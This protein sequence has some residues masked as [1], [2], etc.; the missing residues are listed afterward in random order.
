MYEERYVVFLDLLGFREMIKRSLNDQ[1][2]YTRIQTALQIG[3]TTP[4]PWLPS[5]ESSFKAT[6]ASDSVILSA[7]RNEVG[8]RDILEALCNYGIRLLGYPMMARG[9]VAAGLFTHENW[10]FWGPAYL[11]AMDAE[12][13]RAVYPRI[14]LSQDVA[15]EAAS[16][17]Y[18]EYVRVDQNDSESYVDYCPNNALEFAD[19]WEDRMTRAMLARYL[20]AYRFAISQE[21][22]DTSGPKAADLAEHCAEHFDESDVELFIEIYGFA[23]SDEGMNKGKESS[24]EFAWDWFENHYGK[25]FEKFKRLYS[26]AYRTDGLAMGRDDSEQYAFDNL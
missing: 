4:P 6:A 17:G 5:E 12:G 1:E 14:I 15:K 9:A 24:E 22:M 3:S 19:E 10:G 7:L 11:D 2:G 20:T 26:Y 18:D 23:R 13:Q 25:S 8:L 16:H 21:G